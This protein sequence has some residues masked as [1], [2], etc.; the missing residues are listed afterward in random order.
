MRHHLQAKKN[1]NI[2]NKVSKNTNQ[3]GNLDEV[4]KF[5]LRNQDHHVETPGISVACQSQ[6]PEL[7]SDE[8]NNKVE[9]TSTYSTAIVLQ[10]DQKR[11]AKRMCAN[12]KK[13]TSSS[14][15]D[16]YYKT[17]GSAR[18]VN[19]NVNA[20]NPPSNSSDND[21]FKFDDTFQPE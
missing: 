8:D 4:S 20:K 5:V 13:S 1:T 14:S 2:S 19:V 16:T 10:D 9:F 3:I 6:C 15:T 12:R 21:E 17:G 11:P 7:D 18:K